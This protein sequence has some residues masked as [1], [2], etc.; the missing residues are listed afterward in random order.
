MKVLPSIRPSSIA[1]LV[2][3]QSGLNWPWRRQSEMAISIGRQNPA[4][5][6]SLHKALLHQIRLDDFLDGI[7]GFPERRGNRLD[8]DRPATERFSDQL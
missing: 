6:A 7:A 8:A 2:G 3:E 5:R 4:A 1:V